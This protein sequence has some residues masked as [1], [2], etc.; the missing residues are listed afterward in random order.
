MAKITVKDIL[1]F[2]GVKKISMLTAYDYQFARIF[3]QAKIDILLV[4]D[5]MGMVVY[6]E[7]STLPVT[8]TQTIFHTQAVSRG[9]TSHSLVIGDMPFLSFGV[10]IEK[11]VQNAGRIMKEGGAEAV[12]L[13]GGISRV[14]EIKA[15]KNI[16][17]PVMGHIGLTPQSVHE[18][19]GHKVQGKTAD[20][21][22][23]I[24]DEA[25]A[26]D[27]A[28]VFAIVLEAIPWQIAGEITKNVSVPT[29]GIG[30]GPNCDGHVLVGQDMLG[31]TPLPHPRFVKAYINLDEQISN[32]TVNFKKDIEDGTYPGPEHQYSMPNDEYEK[33][34]KSK[35]L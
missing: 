27:K 31:L 9:A 6:G 28:G 22:D 12:K 8:L 35:N 20:I 4:G 30:A 11:S 25:K 26:L 14:E 13:E 7:T 10:S 33:W 18:F 15:M 16:G 24:I 2:K 32:A 5:S 3:D 19:G 34:K 1:S 29:I 17:I 23:K 21:A